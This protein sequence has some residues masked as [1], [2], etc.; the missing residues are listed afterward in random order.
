MSQ[1]NIIGSEAFSSRRYILVQHM[2]PSL[3]RRRRRPAVVIAVVAVIALLAGIGVALFAMGPALVQQ[4]SPLPPAQPVQT[5]QD[6]A[7]MRLQPVEPANAAAPASVPVAA[8]VAGTP[9]TV[10]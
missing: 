5:A 10:R 3:G 9:A 8:P 7:Q 2:R 1:H 6:I 4:T